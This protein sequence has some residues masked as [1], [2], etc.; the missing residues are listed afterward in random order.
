LLFSLDSSSQYKMLMLFG[1][2]KCNSVKFSIN[3][4][5]PYKF[6]F[7]IINRFSNANKYSVI[8]SIDFFLLLYFLYWLISCVDCLNII[9]F[10]SLLFCC[11]ASN[12]INCSWCTYLLLLDDFY[13]CIISVFSCFIYL[14]NFIL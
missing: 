2:P 11:I 4:H 8:K 6:F 9:Y 13:I 10:C 5:D 14:L 1:I 3:C 7:R 12:L